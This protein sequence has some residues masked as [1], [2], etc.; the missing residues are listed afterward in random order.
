VQQRESTAHR[1]PPAAPPLIEPL[2]PRALE[3]LPLIAQGCSNQEIGERLF[4]VLSTVKQLALSCFFTA[5]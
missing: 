3:G 2:S 4:L 1:S 5:G